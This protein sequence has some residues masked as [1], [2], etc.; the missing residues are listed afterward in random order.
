MG[1]LWVSQG[2]VVFGAWSSSVVLVILLM[3]IQ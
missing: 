2:K 1:S 3:L